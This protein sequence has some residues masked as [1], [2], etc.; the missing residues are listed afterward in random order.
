MSE[1]RSR[2]EVKT[3]PLGDNAGPR[4]A[5][6]HVIA[7][8][9]WEREWYETL[10]IRRAKLLETLSQLHEQMS[11]DPGSEN[12]FVRFF[13]LGGQ[14][15][16]L[17]DVGTVRPDLVTML[18]I[19]NAGGRL[20]LGPW[21][22]IVDEA[23]VCGEALLRNLLTAR[24]D[25]IRYG[26]KLSPVAYVPDM[27]GHISQLPQILRGFEIDAAFLRHGAPSAHVPFRWEAPDGSSIL[28]IN[29]ESR[30]TW[31]PAQMNIFGI[32]DM[33]QAQRAARPDGPFLW[34]FDSGSATRKLTDV[35]AKVEKQTGLPVRQ[36]DLPEY[37]RAI[38]SELP[39]GMRPSLRGELRV[40]SAR[41][42]AYLLPGTLSS[43][44]YL[45]QMNARAQALLTKAV[46]PWL[47]VALSHGRVAH[48][49]NL[50]AQLDYGWRLLLKNQSRNALGGCGGDAV[51][52]ENEVRYQQITDISSHIIATVMD[53]LPGKL[54]EP[55]T[56]IH[57]SQTYV[58]VWNPHNWPVKQMVE[59]DIELP[60]VKYP[61]R[62]IAPNDQEL[63]FSWV[64]GESEHI[65]GGRL[66]FIADVP[67]IGYST[68]RVE[69]GD[70]APS[71]RHHI[72]V[73]PGSAIANANGD[74][75][76]IQDGILVWH[77]GDRV[78]ADVLNF[79]DGGD[80]GDIYNYSPPNPDALIQADLTNDIYVE[81]SPIYERLIIRHR[82]RVAPEL[83][84]DRSRDRG[85][86][87]IEL[88][89]TATF[90]EQVPGVYFRTT[91]TNTA[92]D[93]RLR[94][95][96]RTN[97]KTDTILADAPFDIVERKIPTGDPLMPSAPN[98]E[99]T[100]VTQPAQTV[101]AVSSA[102]TTLALLVRGLPEYQ[103]LSEDNQTTLALT[104]LRAVGWLSRDDLRTRT[105]L[106]A[107][108]VPVPGAQC[109]RDLEA[110][111]ALVY[112]PPADRAALLRAGIEFNAPL[113]AYQ[114]DQPPDRLERSFLS[115]ISNLAIGATS[116]GEGA[117]VT[118][119]KP[120]LKG[121][122]WIVRLFNP[123]HKSVE[124]YL[125]PHKR[126][127]LVQLLTLA[128]DNE[129]FIESDING[130]AAVIVNPHEIVTVRFIFSAPQSSG[131]LEELR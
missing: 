42:H 103:A 17:E 27:S 97:I 24:A 53:A 4:L 104:L 34:L 114:Y 8:L 81:S 121:D 28:V 86:K 16:I 100:A 94:A 95:H 102:D 98:L 12:Q 112:T 38:R 47:T 113:Q 118:A 7:H 105:A 19:Y 32:A 58:V 108:M 117:I 10:E 37:V 126:P 35:A 56:P 60:P 1:A 48:P 69:L 88:T 59:V 57:G 84:P 107:P 23:L 33:I 31:P 83:K 66:G 67:G 119:F 76:T 71:E 29:H 120:P 93:H 116:D 39:D 89:T 77:C 79:V 129:G 91:F 128:E 13:L 11:A 41:E 54:H 131:E 109:L 46:E 130:R 111:Y 65:H 25:A 61:T 36:S 70:E 99:S 68:Y 5:T 125:T 30:T 62:L 64:P 52:A 63:L 15:V 43:R 9:R 72:R 21:Y 73:T 87:L 49:E 106:I 75:L 51:H 3:R 115:V 110:E 101:V 96:I 90:Y 55:M 50:R 122:G 44:I 80:A 45:K 22:V 85:V 40:Q 2:S 74:T 124:V 78:I 6:I 14:T 127:E 20:G 18:V 26:L 123:H 92:K 82:M